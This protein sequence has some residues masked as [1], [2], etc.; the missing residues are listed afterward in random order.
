MA[1]R[2]V[3]K[4]RVTT[5]IVVLLAAG[6]LAAEAQPSGRPARVGFL[7]PS[8]ASSFESGERLINR[9]AFIGRLRELGWIEGQ[10]LVVESRY[11]DG[12]YHR[13]Q[14]LAAELVSVPV[15]VIFANSA[16][17]ALAAKQATTSIPIVFETLGEPISAGLVSS[18]ARPERNLTGISG[19]GPELSGKRLEL[20]RELVPGLRRVT[21]L[22]NPRNVMTAP[23]VR[24]TERAAAILRLRI[25]VVEIRSP[26]QLESAIGGV[27]GDGATAMIIV[28][29]PIL[30]SN[31][32]R[33]QALL[34][35][36]RLP[37]VHAETGWLQAGA[38]MLFGPSLVDHFRQ[39][40]TLVDKV[41][42]GARVANLPV[43][44]STKFQLVINLRT[45]KAF[46]LTI[47]PSLRVRA[48]RLLE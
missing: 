43:E 11:A 35:K 12:A 41:L 19:L 30:L 27:G 33:I 6:V 21:L 24:E 16:P 48:D 4:L 10:N 46:G 40:A 2:M 31:A 22:V 9:E 20:L 47:S 23:T 14:A 28:P 44:Q 42:R 5:A 18:L 13:L 1:K 36:H 7:T 38:L 15:D 29:D 45:A 32:R 26:D 25:E 8:P 37:A 39:A 17:A 34:L 3:M